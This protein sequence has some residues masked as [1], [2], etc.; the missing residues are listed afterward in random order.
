MPLHLF[1]SSNGMYMNRYNRLIRI[2]GDSM[3]V[4]KINRF[5][6][7]LFLLRNPYSSLLFYFKRNLESDSRK[8][9]RETA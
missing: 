2:P 4:T 7:M 6:K 8:C 1:L 3:T 5:D 9:G